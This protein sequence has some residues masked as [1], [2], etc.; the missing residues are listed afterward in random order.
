MKETV[1]RGLV[2]VKHYEG[3]IGKGEGQGET[4]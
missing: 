4:L 1:E 3:D 2:R